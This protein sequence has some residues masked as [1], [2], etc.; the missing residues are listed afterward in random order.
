MTACEA[1]QGTSDTLMSGFFVHYEFVTY[2]QYWCSY[3]LRLSVRQKHSSIES[4]WLNVSSESSSASSLVILFFSRIKHCN[5]ILIGAF[6][7]S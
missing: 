4:K 7:L 3:S 2:L 5:K 6:S 1:V